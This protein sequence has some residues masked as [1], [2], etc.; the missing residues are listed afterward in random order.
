MFQQTPT[1]I[2]TEFSPLTFP[3]TYEILPPQQLPTIQPLTYF[4]YY[5]NPPQM[6][7]P[8]ANL[9]PIANPIKP[10]PQPQPQQNQV[11]PHQQEHTQPQKPIQYAQINGPYGMT[12]VPASGLLTH[13]PEGYVKKGS[14]YVKQDANKQ[15]QQAQQGNQQGNP[16]PQ[17]YN[18]YHSY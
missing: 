10:H 4:P 5:S 12:Y 14:L 15:G 18:P 9:I 2:F 7:Y 3:T 17:A 8:H 16:Q 11:Q 13:L 1:P 6:I